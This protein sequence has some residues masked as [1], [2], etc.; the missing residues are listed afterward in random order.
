MDSDRPAFS[1]F[2]GFLGVWLGEERTTQ[3]PP[4]KI[5]DGAPSAYQWYF[6]TWAVG[7]SKRWA[8]RH[9]ASC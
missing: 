3:D 6:L 4:L 5:K 8:A 2:R 1:F 9:T 7:I